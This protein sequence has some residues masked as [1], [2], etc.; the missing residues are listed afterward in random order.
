MTL[1][2]IVN[3]LSAVTPIVTT[4]ASAVSGNDEP[5]RV[6]ER[7]ENPSVTNNSVSI[8]INNNFYTTSE[9]EAKQIACDMQ[10]ELLNAISSG[11]RY[12]L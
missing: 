7:K 4:I 12:R 3:V 8:T 2:D 1:F 11:N 9:R 6:I 10:N 5:E